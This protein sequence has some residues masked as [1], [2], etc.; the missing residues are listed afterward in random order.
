VDEGEYV[1]IGP[2]ISPK[3]DRIFTY[4]TNLS[5]PN[6]PIVLIHGFAAGSALW[7]TNIDALAQDRP[8]YTMD[9]IGRSC[10]P[11]WKLFH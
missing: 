6:T 10:R 8:L 11:V 3:G 4:R 5:S 9:L 7:C 1:E 2:V